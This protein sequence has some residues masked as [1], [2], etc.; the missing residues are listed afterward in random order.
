MQTTFIL[1]RH[2]YG[3]AVIPP[4]FLMRDPRLRKETEVTQWGRGR[5]ESQTQL[6]VSPQPVVFPMELS[7]TPA[8]SKKEVWCAALKPWKQA[9]L[10]D[11]C[12]AWICP[13][14]RP[15]LKKQ[16]AR[17]GLVRVDPVGQWESGAP[18][19]SS[20][21]RPREFGLCPAPGCFS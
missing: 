1:T 21:A 7:C 9:S 13:L 12:L 5:A 20:Q 4:I 19:F 17:T 3:G 14:A 15:Q 18:V 16:E 11:V 2:L 6:Q 8:N 10:S